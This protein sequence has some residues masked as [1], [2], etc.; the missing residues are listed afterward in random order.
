MS[1]LY[2]Y[3]KYPLNSGIVPMMLNYLCLL[4]SAQGFGL[5]LLAVFPNYRFALSAASLIGMISFSIAGFSFASAAMAPMLYGL[6]FLFPL[7]HFF[8]IYVDQALNGLPIG[9]SMYN[10][11]A[12][13]GFFLIG[14]LCISRVGNFLYKNIYED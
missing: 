1:V 10:Y 2:G 7:R 5:I 13:L 9:Y 14:L 11:A 8:L 6:S 4:L 3:N 12:L